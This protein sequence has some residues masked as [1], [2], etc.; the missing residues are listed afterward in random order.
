ML[1]KAYIWILTTLAVLAV[2]ALGLGWRNRRK[3]EQAQD[4][5][6]KGRIEDAEVKARVGSLTTK[7]DEVLKPRVDVRKS[8]EVVDEEL[9][10]RGLID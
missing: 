9:R 10:R 5:L 3:A 6:V 8:Q 7:L 2:G 1:R 4:A